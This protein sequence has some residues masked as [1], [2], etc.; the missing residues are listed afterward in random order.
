MAGRGKTQKNK[1]G[2]IPETLK[3]DANWKDAVKDALN[4]PSIGSHQSP[5]P[6]QPPDNNL[7]CVN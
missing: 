2:P 1:C 6:E 5:P 3:I 4:S 7:K